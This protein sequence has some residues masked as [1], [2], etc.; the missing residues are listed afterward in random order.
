MNRNDCK[1]REGKIHF[2]EY[3]FLDGYQ[4][5]LGNCRTGLKSRGGACSDVDDCAAACQIT[6]KEKHSNIVTENINNM[7]AGEKLRE[8][9]HTE[10]KEKAEIRQRKEKEELEK[11]RIRE[12]AKK[13]GKIICGDCGEKIDPKTTKEVKQGIIECTK[14]NKKING[15]TGEVILGEEVKESEKKE[16][17]KKE[18]PVKEVKPAEVIPVIV[19][20]AT[21]PPVV[22]AKEKI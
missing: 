10:D 2:S 16:E 3:G 19:S 8:K 17:K 1:D 4:G 14:C 12:E 21:T 7:T 15:Q 18:E 13:E 5:S 11:N 9:E 20:P 6:C 22:E